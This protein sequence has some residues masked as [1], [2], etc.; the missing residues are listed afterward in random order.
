N[1][2]TKGLLFQATSDANASEEMRRMMKEV[3]DRAARMLDEDPAIARQPEVEAALHL[4]IGTTYYKL[5]G[6]DQE[7][8][9][10]LSRA[11]F[12][13]QHAPGLGPEHPTT[14]KAQ[15]ALVDF[16]DEGARK[17]E[18]AASLGRRTWEARTRVLGPRNRDT[19][20]SM[21]RYAQILADMR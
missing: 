7:A 13:R 20:A 10:H 3:L 21:S 18:P 17:F 4:A 12:L 2:L 6:Q 1:F 11:V 15:Q 9:A 14:L 8:E 19:L 16:L 5:G